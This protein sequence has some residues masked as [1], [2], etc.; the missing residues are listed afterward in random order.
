MPINASELGDEMLTQLEEAGF[1]VDDKFSKQK[2][3]V[4]AI[5]IAIVAHFKTNAVV[6]VADAGGLSPSSNI[7][8]PTAGTGGIT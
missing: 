1:I 6:T 8:N 5:A 7:G 3:F 4:D 2:E